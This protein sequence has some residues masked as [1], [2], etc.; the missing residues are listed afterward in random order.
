[1]RKNLAGWCSA[2]L[3]SS[4]CAYAADAFQIKGTVLDSAA[5]TPVAGAE[6]SLP[7]AKVKTTTDASG[8]FTLGGNSTTEISDIQAGASPFT[9]SGQTISLTAEKTASLS[10]SAYDLRGQSIKIFKGTVSHGVHSFDLSKAIRTPGIYA[11]R[12]ALGVTTWTAMMHAADK[13][14]APVKAG[15]S[16]ALRLAQASA[17]DSLIVAKDGY[18]T[19]RLALA[20]RNDSVSVPM[21]IKA[22]V[23]QKGTAATKQTIAPGGQIA[24]LTFTWTGAPGISTEGLSVKD[25]PAGKLLYI[26]GKVSAGA[27]AKAYPY[28]VS[29]T[30]G[31]STAKFTDTLIVRGAAVSSSSAAVS[32]S[33]AAKSSSST[34]AAASSASIRNL[35]ADG[36]AGVNGS[37]TGGGNVTPDTVSTYAAFKA[38]VQASAAKIVVVSGTIRTTD[39]DGYALQIASNKTIVGL[40]KN[41][42]IYGGITFKNVSNVI[43]RNLNM[44][45]VYPNSGPDDAISV[46]NSNHIWFDHLNIWNGTDGNLD[47]T[48]QSSYVTVSWCKF[49]YTDANHPHRLNALIGSGAADHPEDWGYL[50]VTYQHCWFAEL[51]SERMP[52][53]MYGQAHIY[54]NYYTSKGNLYCIGV[55]SYAAALIEGNYFKDVK[56]PHLFMYNIYANMTVRNNK[57]DNTTGNKDS[58]ALGERYI[59]TAPYTLLEKPEALETVPYKYTADAAADVPAIVSKGAGPQF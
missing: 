40:N 26:S 19:A 4:V 34:A 42:T 38:A 57:Y 16:A 59:T 17:W 15:E 9:L 48:N 18:D 39:G 25:D 14:A 29:T 50:K 43:V 12:I 3:L 41:S 2:I 33:S 55:G 32:S 5:G 21:F 51:V 44:Q 22:S 47:I 58:G 31:H 35:V 36:Y 23:S 45:G 53:V 10:I 6:V 37:T 49:W 24:T 11:I 20:S 54:N 28:T 30:G 1:M 8:Y 46:H 52:R 27:A 13:S 7:G 56:S